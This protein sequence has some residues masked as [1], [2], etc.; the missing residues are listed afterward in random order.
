V[1]TPTLI[2]GNRR[3]VALALAIIALT[4]AALAVGFANAIGDL[5]VQ[6]Q[7]RGQ[8]TYLPAFAFSIAMGIAMLAER[9][10]AERF[11]QSFVLDC[12]RSI[13]ENV[14]RNSGDDRPARWLTALVGDLTA[15]RNYAVRGSVKLWTSLLAGIAASFWFWLNY[16]TSQ[17]VLMPFLLGLLLLLGTTYFLRSAIAVQRNTRGKLNRFLIRRVQIEAS[18]QSTPRRHGYRRLQ[19]LSEDLSRKVQKRAF[20]FGIM[21]CIAIICGGLSAVLVIIIDRNPASNAM[22]IGQISLIGFIAT[23]LLETARAM[24]AQAGG[25]IALNRLKRLLA[26]APIKSTAEL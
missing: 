21:E 11:A 1:K 23:R 24:H 15:I 22:I 5:V 20:I 12:R 6:S 13:F 3:I 19:D 25:Q 18:G 14:V 8:V 26:I 9:A 4:Q 2:S 10:T 7:Q 16:P 17:F